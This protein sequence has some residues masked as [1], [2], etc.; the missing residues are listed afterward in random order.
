MIVARSD[1]TQ[2]SYRTRGRLGSWEG[3]FLKVIGNIKRSYTL[4]LA[5]SPTL[6]LIESPRAIQYLASNVSYLAHIRPHEIL[7]IHILSGKWLP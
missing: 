7:L 4:A 1:M 2:P 5:G 6:V 3:M